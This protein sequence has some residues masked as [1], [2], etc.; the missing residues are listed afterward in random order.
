MAIPLLVSCTGD[1]AE[2]R[3]LSDEAERRSQSAPDDHSV[4][5]KPGDGTFA[6][7]PG[8]EAELAAAEKLLAEYERD[9]RTEEARELRD[10]LKAARTK[11]TKARTEGPP[12][13]DFRNPTQAMI[14]DAK[15]R[16]IDLDDPAVLQ[17]L[18]EL[19]AEQRETSTPAGRAKKEKRD[20]AAQEA[21]KLT[22]RDLIA[23]LKA[24]GVD[25]GHC[26]TKT[27]LK[28]LFVAASVDVDEA[29]KAAK[30]AVSHKATSHKAAEE[31]SSTKFTVVFALVFLA[32]RL[33]ST[34]LI[35]PLFASLFGQSDGP[36]S[37][38]AAETAK[39]HRNPYLDAD[40]DDAEFATDDHW[41]S[42]F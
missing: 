15:K 24:L 3:K 42:E 13:M 20:A 11:L 41:T 35:G 26:D 31:V 10:G 5:L 1:E 9:G 25:H 12:P 33:Y 38:I 8:P 27:E 18:E 7:T 17:M 14:D 32:Y 39:A 16:G 4:A 29:R 22:M 19:Q 37:P 30:D 36:A 2:R 40:A 28:D 6:S 23:R 21:E 34:N